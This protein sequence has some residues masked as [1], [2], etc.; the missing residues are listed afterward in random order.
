[1][2]DVLYAEEGPV[3]LVTLNRPES[4]NA[5]NKG[6]RTG[7]I[8]AM[9]RAAES[10][11]TRA[12]VIG[13][14]GRGFSAGA[15]LAEQLPPETVTAVLEQEYLPGILAITQLPKPVIAA[16]QGFAAGIGVSYAL[17][18]DLVVMGEKTFMQVPFSK[19]ALVPDGGLNW[20]LAQRLGHRLAFEIAVEGERLPAVRCRDLGLANR[21]VPEDKVLEEAKAWAARLAAQAP[22]AIAGTKQ[23]LRASSTATLEEVM[24][25]EVRLQQ[26]CVD[27]ADFKEGIQAFFEK[28]AP[29]FTGA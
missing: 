20:Q 25:L 27:S 11:S 29:R 3:A 18:C 7:F 6:A 26:S 4:L 19:I 23:A 8:E 24:A 1:M 5:F 10:K 15:D 22:L 21:V 12:V 16:V 14:A 17:A 28:R 2:T 9:Q 13:A